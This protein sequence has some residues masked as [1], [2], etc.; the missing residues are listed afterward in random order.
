MGSSSAPS[1][2]RADEGRSL[3]LVLAMSKSGE[4]NDFLIS[5]GE[6]LSAAMML[7]LVVVVRYTLTVA[8]VN[9]KETRIGTQLQGNVKEQLRSLGDGARGMHVL[10][11]CYVHQF[12]AQ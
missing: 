5:C 2:R 9:S 8:N 10:C 3:L 11:T 7:E 1:F 12:F 4:L 6:A